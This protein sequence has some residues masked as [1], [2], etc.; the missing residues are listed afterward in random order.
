MRLL[1]LINNLF[2]FMI[3]SVMNT[4]ISIK[5]PL[6]IF[7]IDGW[8]FRTRR[9]EKDGAFYQH[10][11]GVRRWKSLLPELS[12]FLSFLFSKKQ[13]EH[14]G[15]GYL[16]RFAQ[17]TC[18]AELVHWCIMI[19]MLLYMQWAHTGMSALMFFIAVLCNLPYIIIQRYNRPRILNILVNKRNGLSENSIK[20]LELLHKD[21]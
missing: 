1:L 2:I 20:E 15:S 13:M 11:F 19:S 14:S 7:H 9:W 21:I 4:L 18:R 3:L 17:E 16:Y 12:D 6:S 10:W 5:L 8:L